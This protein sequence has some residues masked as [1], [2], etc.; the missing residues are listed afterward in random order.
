[1]LHVCVQFLNKYFNPL[2]LGVDFWK[3]LRI[4]VLPLVYF[5]LTSYESCKKQHP[6]LNWLN[7]I[8]Y[9]SERHKL[10][11]HTLPYKI[12]AIDFYFIIQLQFLI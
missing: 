11:G 1:M 6:N 7:R 2:V 4:V 3:F 12:L 10:R 8:L 5:F 9:R